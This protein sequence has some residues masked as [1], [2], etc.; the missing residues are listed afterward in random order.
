LDIVLKLSSYKED[1]YVETPA[2]SAIK[3]MA[4]SFPAVLRVL[5][6]RLCSTSPDEREHAAHAICDI[7]SEEPEI[8][9][10]EELEDALL[11]LKS[12]GDAEAYE[13]LAKA[14][15][16]VKAVEHKPQYRYGF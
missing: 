1:W 15:S 2:N 8:L 12:I 13:R 7:A 14:L 10:A 11:Q 4:R 9:S 16:K 6:G 3:A 5:F